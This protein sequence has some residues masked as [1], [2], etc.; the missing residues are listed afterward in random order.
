MRDVLR[1]GSS[2]D[3][4]HAALLLAPTHNLRLRV[5]PE[6][7]TKLAAL[8]FL[9]SPES[10]ACF[11]DL[12]SAGRKKS[13][14][15]RKN[16]RRSMQKWQEEAIEFTL[17]DVSAFTMAR[18]VEEIYYP[19]FVTCFFARGISPYGAHNLETFN[20]FVK[21]E[22]LLALA[23]RGGKLVGAALLQPA[24][25]TK[26]HWPVCGERPEGQCAEGLIV[27]ISDSAGDIRR[28]FVQV[29]AITLRS[30]GYDWLCL[31]RDLTWMGPRY[32]RVFLEKLR[33]AD[34]VTMCMSDHRYFF[35]WKPE[36]AAETGIF[37]NSVHGE[38]D[39]IQFGEANA[40]T[41]DIRSR[42][43]K[44]KATSNSLDLITRIAEKS[45]AAVRRGH[46]HVE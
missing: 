27:A 29:L 14:R 17:T 4:I 11:V 23:Y 46:L 36:T 5:L 25:S 35:S 10:I 1:L 18:L 45:D 13:V 38:L 22:M 43:S 31:G 32:C 28:A 33:Y 15:V 39:V 6:Q 34:V 41:N 30:L 16:L 26:A 24:F 20:E 42:L 21:P 40:T 19:L 7:A 3:E 37:F 12:H 8:G 2:P 9:E 44:V